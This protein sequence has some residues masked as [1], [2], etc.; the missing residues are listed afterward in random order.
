MISPEHQH[1]QPPTFKKV[2]LDSCIQIGRD[3]H[4]DQSELCNLGQLDDDYRPMTWLYDRF[5]APDIM[6]L[7]SHHI[8]IIYIDLLHS[9]SIIFLDNLHFRHS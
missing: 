3:S 4:L 5:T 2:D 1:P 7:S 9:E 8:V 6:C